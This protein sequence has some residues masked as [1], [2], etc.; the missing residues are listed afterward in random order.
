M[1]FEQIKS[2]ILAGNII[3]SDFPEKSK[4]HVAKYN[5]IPTRSSSAGGNKNLSQRGFLQLHECIF[6]KSIILHV[7]AKN[8]ILK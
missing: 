5:N 6:Q 1:E 3:E 2:S 8:D 7:F 4:T